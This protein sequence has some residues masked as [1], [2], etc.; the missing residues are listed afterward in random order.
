MGTGVVWGVTKGHYL[1]LMWAQYAS[2]HSPA[3]SR[4]RKALLQVANDLYQATVNQSLTR[5]MVTGKPLT[6]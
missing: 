3:M 4:D 1:I 5:R 6:P 2:L